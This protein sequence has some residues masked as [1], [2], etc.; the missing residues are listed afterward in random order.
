MLNEAEDAGSVGAVGA[1]EP[2]ELSMG[3]NCP[4]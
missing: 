3:E 2:L 4:E 1:P